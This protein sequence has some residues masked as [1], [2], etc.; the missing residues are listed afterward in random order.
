MHTIYLEH[1]D[2]IE[3]VLDIATSYLFF[4]FAKEVVWH[5]WTC[6]PIPLSPTLYQHPVAL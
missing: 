2:S 4:H 6:D 5:E 3:K 1:K